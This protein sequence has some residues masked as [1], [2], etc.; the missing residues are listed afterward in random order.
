MYKRFTYFLIFNFQLSKWRT[1]MGRGN[2]FWQ[3]LVSCSVWISVFISG[4]GTRVTSAMC[5]WLLCCPVDL[6]NL[7]TQDCS[8]LKFKCFLVASFTDLRGND[9]QETMGKRWDLKNINESR[10]LPAMGLMHNVLS[11]V[12]LDYCWE[13][14]GSIQVSSLRVSANANSLWKL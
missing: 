13:A 6:T 14:P 11:A 9:C 2:L 5:E 1:W 4:S 8:L 12:R 3:T 10:Q 7:R